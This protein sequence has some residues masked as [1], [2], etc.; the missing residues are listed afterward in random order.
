MLLVLAL[1]FALGWWGGDAVRAAGWAVTAVAAIAMFVQA[2]ARPLARVLRAGAVSRC[3]GKRYP[4]LASDVL[5]ADQL[6]RPSAPGP[7]SEELVAHHLAQVN[8]RLRGFPDSSVFPVTQIVWPALA[9]S[10]A[11]CAWATAPARFPGVVETGVNALWGE[12]RLPR[13][14]PRTVVKSPVVSDLALTLRYPEY[15]GRDER[16]LEGISGGFAAPLGTTVTL[17]GKPLVEGCTYGAVSLPGEREETL[18]LTEDGFVRG[19]FVISQAGSFSILLGTASHVVE[20]PQRA[21]EIEVD[22]P[23]A[24]RLL[25]P[26]GT[27]EVDKDGSLTLE[28]EGEDDH[29]L[30]R[31][32]LVLRTGG[33]L[34]TRRTLAH[35]GDRVRR[36]RTQYLWSPESIRV[37]EETS[38]QLELEALD[39]DTILGPKP[40]R[41]EPLE[42][43]ILTP[44]S[45]HLSSLRDQNLALDALVDLLAHRLE[46]PPLPNRDRRKA[47]ERFT[48]L[49]RETEDVL[50]RT[51]RLIPA[52]NSDELTPRRVAEVYAQIRQDLSNQLFFEAQMHGDT[53]ADLRKRKTADR[54]TVRLLESAVL[55]V[56]DL[57]I[58]QQLGQLTRSGSSLA[59]QKGRVFELLENFA[60]RRTDASRRALLDAV[61]EIEEAITK[62]HNQVEKIRGRVKDEYLS[63]AASL[64]LD[65]IG[66]LTRLRDLIANGNID[67]AKALLAGF[68]NDLDKLMTSLESGL[69]AF[70]T[71]RFSESDRFVGDLLDRVL[72]VESDQLQLRR[73]TIALQRRYREKLVEEMRGRI[74]PLVKKQLGRVEQIRALIDELQKEAAGNRQEDILRLRIA[75]RELALALDQGDLEEARRS[76]T[77]LHEQA[78]DWF[79][80]AENASG[81]PI[82][83]IG[84]A[85]ERVEREVKQAFPKPG[86]LLSQRDR[87][88][89]RVQAVTQR[90]L[91]FRT[92]KLRLWVTENTEQARFLS[93][94]AV[95]AL[96]HVE[97]EMAGAVEHLEKQ[98][99]RR[100]LESQSIALE[101]LGHLRDELRRG[102]KT[103]RVET[104]P[105]VLRGRVEV[106]DPNEYEVPP[107]FREDIIQAMQDDLPNNYEDAI[108]K[109]YEMLVR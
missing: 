93:G 8:E 94:R 90:H 42:V 102:D 22:S 39:D 40:G 38:L 65:L 17:I 1:V 104:R 79:M 49:R 15:L 20:G 16:R 89:T 27:V 77:L 98:V 44:K 74:D 13:S 61:D 51:A 95:K 60:E 67:E 3:I 7:F 56:D 35:L 58:E 86:Q 96:R 43:R 107:E 101:E 80:D 46:N 47:N 75:S 81:G 24:I 91:L 100:A 71:D 72:A 30:R 12:R 28:I 97:S 54:V 45:R 83:E 5:S 50:G 9:L 99:A 92:Q 57:I 18:H 11:L 68:E 14:R 108:K 34:E 36:V 106:P 70:R 19:K 82:E 55:R 10:G 6:A 63:S 4:E 103:A 88:K 37:Q 69:M 64:Q 59:D 23:P 73:K 84:K 105:I 32:D 31:I 2:G 48:L 29:G 33:G 62:L 25:R 85:A 52:L 78:E 76:A 26:S 21:I 109:Y 66:S 53:L 87:Q 41:S